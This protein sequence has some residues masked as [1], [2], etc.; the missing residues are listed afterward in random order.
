LGL[1]YLN[2]PPPPPFFTLIQLT[3]NVES[4]EIILE[5]EGTSKSSARPVLALN[6][7]AVFQLF[8]WTGQVRIMFPSPSLLFFS[9]PIP[10][11]SPPLSLSHPSPFVPNPPP[12]TPYLPHSS[13]I[14]PF[15]QLEVAGEV[16]AEATYYNQTLSLWEP[17]LETVER[18]DGRQELWDL[19]IKVCHAK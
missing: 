14:L 5:D 18:K 9:S 12:P 3:L 15:P 4:V 16:H 6:S 2:S 1:E 11:P 10:V 8:E 13:S 17:I 7:T 19:Q